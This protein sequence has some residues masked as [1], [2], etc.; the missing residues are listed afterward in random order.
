MKSISLVM[1]VYNEADV[2][3]TVI[4]KYSA[5]LKKIP[6]SEFVICEDGSTD[7]TKELLRTLKKK[8]RLTLYQSPKRKGAVKGFINSLAHAKKDIVWFSD[9]DDTH[10][11]NDFFKLYTHLADAD[12]VI[13]WK[14]P[15]MDPFYRL[16]VSRIFNVFIN[17]I[18][19]TQFHDINSGFRLIRK[20]IVQE[21]LPNIG[22][23]PGCTLTELTL[24]AIKRGYRISEIPV[25]HYL[26]EGGSRAIP[27]KKLPGIGY[28]VFKEILKIR[29]GS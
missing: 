11:P 2:I 20:N 16:L 13:G 21:L 9:S 25:T 26:R 6:N 22:N 28:G 7:G 15:R 1:P 18:F 14:H 12:M 24:H 5:V 4:E 23:F 8:Y 29:F 17:L 27:P 19:G 3:K 10:D